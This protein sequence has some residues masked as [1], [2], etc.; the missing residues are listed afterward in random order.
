ME[1]VTA[2]YLYFLGQ[3]IGYLY[4]SVSNT[5]QTMPL[6]FSL[7]LFATEKVVVEVEKK[8]VNKSCFQFEWE[9]FKTHSF[10]ASSRP[11]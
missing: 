10:P 1:I 5:L 9:K 6:Y 2:G 8:Q 11:T 3:I 7:S 4:L